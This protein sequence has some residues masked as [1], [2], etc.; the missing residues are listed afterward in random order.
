MPLFLR[1]RELL[2]GA[3]VALLP[4]VPAWAADHRDSPIVDSNVATDITDIYMFRDPR[5]PKLLVMV[6]NTHPFSVP[7]EATS[8]H[9]DPNALYRFYFSTRK[10]AEPTAEIDFVF[11]PFQN[12]GQSFTAYF[13]RGIV[14][15]GPV[16]LATVTSD[17]PNPPAITEGPHGIK[18]FAGPRDDPFFFDFV[19]FERLLAG[20]G[21][22]TGTDAFAGFNVNSIVV[23]VPLELV[24]GRAIKFGAWGVTYDSQQPLLGPPFN[25][26]LTQIDRMGNPAV[27]T[28]F[29][30]GPLKDAYNFGQPQ[31]D[32]R[33]FG[34]TIVNTL[35]GLGT[36]P[37]NIAILAS[38]AVPDTLK[39]DVTKPDGFPNGRQLTDRSTDIILSFVFNKAVTDGTPGNDVPLL[40]RFPFLAPPHQATA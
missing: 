31:N 22:F 18:I 24:V 7:Q 4:R 14:V 17:K 2:I 13:P 38:V 37:D 23:Q 12:G 15:Q 21:G 19:G 9:Y 33:D 20:T 29:I 30:L 10:S 11:S 1:R 26:G 36:S 34:P 32:A 8:Y 40:S 6:M 25:A 5:D 16:T 35:T 28:V 3:G 27:N 39:F